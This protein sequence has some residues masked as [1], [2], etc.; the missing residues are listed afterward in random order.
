MPYAVH[1]R[2]PKSLWIQLENMTT[3]CCQEQFMEMIYDTSNSNC[4]P[5]FLYEEK[6]LDDDFFPQQYFH[7]MR[8][9]VNVVSLKMVMIRMTMRRQFDSVSFHKR[10]TEFKREKELHSIPSSSEPNCHERLTPTYTRRSEIYT[11]ID[12]LK[13]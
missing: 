1:R 3:V 13:E 11:Y 9:T 4:L 2:W 12:T 6:S 8:T 10:M 5:F 7:L